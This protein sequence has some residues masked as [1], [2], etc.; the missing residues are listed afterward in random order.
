MVQVLFDTQSAVEDLKRGGFTDDQAKA[1][2]RFVR[3]A[4]EG[5]VA[6][7]ADLEALGTSIRVEFRETA[8]TLSG[9]T[10]AVGS[11]LDATTID[12]NHKI[13]LLRADTTSLEKRIQSE[14]KAFR[15]QTI[16]A[17]IGASGA[18]GIVLKLFD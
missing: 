8:D 4:L 16:A 14:M 2:V 5:G 15:F 7:K 18:L 17:V 12:L 10:K 13:D 6:T 1:N 3:E 9:E 11:T